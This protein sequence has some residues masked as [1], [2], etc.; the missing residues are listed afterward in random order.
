MPVC[1]IN[2]AVGGSRIDQHQK[3]PLQPEDPK[4]IYGRMLRRVA[5]ARLSHGI[6][7]VIWH[8][9]ENDQGAAG[10]DDGYGWETYQQYFVDMSASWKED[11]PNIQQ[12]YMFQIWPDACSMGK[13]GSGD[14]LRDV[15][16]TLPSKYSNLSIMSTLGIRPGGGC[17]FPPEGYAE[18]ADL[19]LPLIERDN[20]GINY[21]KAITPPNL[22]KAYFTSQRRNEVAIIFDQPMD[23]HG[24]LISEFYLDGDNSMIS[25]GSLWG[26]MILLKLNDRS[27]AKTISYLDGK[28]WNEKN[29][30]YGRNGI[31]ALSFFEV[32]IKSLDGDL[33]EESV[34]GRSPLIQAYPYLSRGDFS[35]EVVNESPDPLVS[36]RWPDPKAEDGLEVFVIKPQK[37]DTESPTSFEGLNSLTGNQ[38]YITVKGKGA[39]RI[40]FGLEMP[41]W[42]EFDSHDCPG[43]VEMSI[44]EYNQPGVNKTS[45]PIRHGDTY[46]LELND[47]LYDG[48]RFAW[49]HVNTHTKDW[50]I[51]DVRA[52]NQ[53]KPVNY[54]GSFSC[55]DQMLT[56]IWYMSAYS[57]RASMCKD[58][59]GAIIMDRGDRMSWTGD[60]H[61]IQ[62]AS[63]VAFAN[64]DFIKKNLDN[65]AHQDNG[66]RSYSLYWVLSLL[67]Y[68]HYTGDK[69]TLEKYLNNAGNKLDDAYIEFGKD[70]N[71]GFYGWDERLTAGFEL[72]FKPAPEAQRA[73][74]M[75]TIRAWLEFA[76]VMKKIGRADL[77]SKY[78]WWA[79]RKMAEMRT[80]KNW[81]KD[82]GLHSAVDAI[83]TKQLS[84]REIDSIYINVLVNRENRLSL[85]PFNQ[86]FVIQALSKIN[87]HDDA[88]SSVKDIWGGMIEQ[89]A[90]TP[91]EVFRPSWN[92][93]LQPN[94]PVPNSQSGIVSLCHPWGAGPVK[95][96]NEEVLGIKPSSP[97]FKSWEIIPHPGKRLEWIK[98]ETPT[99][100]G[101]I[102]IFFD[103]IDGRFHVSAPAGTKGRIGIPRSEIVIKSISVN[104]ELAWNGE[105][106]K[107]KGLGGSSTDDEYIYF[108]DVEAGEYE[109][110]YQYEGNTSF[111]VEPH[112]QF[113]SDYIGID[114]KTKG[115]WGGKYG[116]NGYVLC[117]YWGDGADEQALPDYVDSISY[118]RAFPKTKNNT[119]GYVLWDE[120][121]TDPR[122]LASSEENE[123]VR[124][125]SAVFNT[126][127][128]MTFTAHL[129][130][131]RNYQIALYFLDWEDEGIS[132]AVEMFD[133][134]TLTLISPV[135]KISDFKG[136]KY[137]IFNYNKSVKFRINKIRGK[138]SNLS[139]I[140]F[141][142]QK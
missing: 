26:N 47:E 48:V 92:D 141:D 17:H 43:G 109:I 113:L 8:Q 55:S 116:K 76:E 127:E 81:L 49:I 102:R 38:P 39:I 118:F 56:K 117:N 25:S 13:N 31:A 28:N 84:D 72:W 75:L 86:Y 110:R 33:P 135:K 140:F 15:Q 88:M 35:G 61:P 2:G 63:L 41:A 87:K 85:S 80:E 70:P 11:F 79:R 20:Y 132:Q 100:Y 134:E 122:A 32:T 73:Y 65:T 108:D 128:T 98:G 123:L 133:A 91:Y 27:D 1:I 18:M 40:D 99:P 131:T 37:V 46:R 94:D 67:D 69:E 106:H 129:N 124:T 93:F 57:V 3:N 74:R 9:G 4:T 58:Y 77:E 59:F 71:L 29:I 103:L 52:I 115:D 111:Y 142:P 10:P 112:F 138:R 130:R 89:G 105:F 51:T 64:Y 19:I 62:A 30:L 24:D 119:P 137:L 50:H 97:G 42:I 114:A 136:G 22:L 90:T 12:Y 125:A 23:W 54:K 7:G 104:G 53:V 44:S 68:Y 120:S 34:M 21:G 36:Y 107:V 60:A 96:L 82:Y 139:G 16:R 83:N 14:R 101:N 45:E 95:W 6:R 121:T 78:S 126:G 5:A 66:I